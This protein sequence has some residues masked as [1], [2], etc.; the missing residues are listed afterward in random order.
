MIKLLLL[1]VDGTLTDGKIYYS[2]QGEEIKAFNIKDGLALRA[3][4]QM[5]RKS[6]IVTGRKSTLVQKRADELGIDFVF[7][8]VQNKGEIVAKLQRELNLET[9]E[10]ASIG[11]DV[12]DLSMF[13]QSGLSFAPKDGAKQILKKVSCILDSKGG[14]GAVREMIERIL[15]EEHLEEQ[16]LELFN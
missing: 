15:I 11:D 2:N 7:M 9:N 5:G 12:N 1:D 3:W 16:W 13:A 6:A 4:N 10:I 14:Y 8:G